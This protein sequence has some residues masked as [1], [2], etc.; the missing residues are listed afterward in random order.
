MATEERIKFI[1]NL[2]LA[3]PTYHWLN[4]YA[5][6]NNSNAHKNTTGPEILNELNKVDY[7]FIGSGTT[8]TLNGCAQ[9]FR[10]H[11]PNTKIIAVE[12]EG[13]VTF[14]QPPKK[15][16]IPGLGTSKAPPLANKKIPDQ[17]L[18]VSE[19]DTIQRCHQILNKYG[20][21]LGGS[22]GTVLEGVWQYRHQIKKKSIIVAISPDFGNN[23]LDTLYDD[24][25]VTNNFSQIA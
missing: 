1:E 15:R 3:N 19:I 7:L 9:Y 11:S 16:Q 18:Y 5:N 20:L 25:W 14:G 10:T 12:P 22:S 21:F 24:T 13:S 6:Q 17:I 4:Q 2:L 23:Y 8:G